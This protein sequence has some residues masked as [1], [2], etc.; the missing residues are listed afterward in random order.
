MSDTPATDREVRL[1]VLELAASCTADGAV[2]LAETFMAFLEPD[3]GAGGG[4]HPVH[5]V[6]LRAPYGE[7][8]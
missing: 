8:A 3:A 1:R 5:G 2:A 6:A 7:S 4:P